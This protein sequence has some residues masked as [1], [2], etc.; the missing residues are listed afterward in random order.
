MLVV[1]VFFHCLLMTVALYLPKLNSEQ[2]VI[3]P[4]FMV[5][6]MESP[7]APAAPAPSPVVNTPAAEK[8]MPSPVKKMAPKPVAKP[9]PKPAPVKRVTTPKPPPR[10]KPA[11][12]PPVVKPAVVKKREPSKVLKELD[13]VASLT[14]KKQTM[15]PVPSKPLLEETVRELEALKEEKVVLPIPVKPRQPFQAPA[16]SHNREAL[17]NED[18]EFE[19]LLESRPEVAPLTQPETSNK[20]LQ[21]LE[22]LQEL[23]A[24][25]PRTVTEPSVPSQATRTPEP[26][27]SKVSETLSKLNALRPGQNN[28]SIG[29]R[30]ELEAKAYQSQLRNV[31][32]PEI[33]NTVIPATRENPL[34]AE[35]MTRAGVP[36][37]QGCCRVM[38]R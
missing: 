4:A 29:A 9:E 2:K 7:S 24:A 33:K 1:S 22:N 28:V 35:V 17:K 26:S 21:E 16:V 23:K 13:Q 18:R 12:L 3:K 34:K 27:S 36:K 20:L 25:L 6:L 30:A 38:S 37:M 10:V 19:S 8:N 32:S 5:Q 31:Q 14:R 11:P 15:A